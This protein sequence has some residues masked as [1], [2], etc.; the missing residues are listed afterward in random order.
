MSWEMNAK[1][2]GAAYI[3]NGILRYSSNFPF[4]KRIMQALEITEYQK[5]SS[6]GILLMYTSFHFIINS[7]ASLVSKD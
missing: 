4:R 7:E 3:I 6:I 1:S 2:L 5:S